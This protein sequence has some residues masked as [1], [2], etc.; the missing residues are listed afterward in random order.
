MIRVLALLLPVAVSANYAIHYSSTNLHPQVVRNGDEVKFAK[1]PSAEHVADI[2]AR[3]S[4]LPPLLHEGI[5]L[6]KIIC[7]LFFKIYICIR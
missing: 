6:S 2:Y 7:K 3:L 1:P 5:N 4:G